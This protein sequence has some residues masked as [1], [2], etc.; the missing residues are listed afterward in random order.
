[1]PLGAGGCRRALTRAYSGTHTHTRQTQSF[2][3][4]CFCGSHTSPPPVFL[5]P[6]AP[7]LIPGIHNVGRSLAPPPSLGAALLLAH[8]DNLSHTRSS[9]THTHTHTH[10]HSLRRPL[11]QTGCAHGFAHGYA[12][13]SPT[14][15]AL[16]LPSPPAF[17]SPPASPAVPSPT[18]PTQRGP[19]GQRLVPGVRVRGAGPKGMLPWY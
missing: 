4:S 5:S 15:T 16:L 10:T 19:R 17:S 1:M 13:G 3:A 7:P 14:A 6:L 12:H 11:P 8:R 18:Q 2:A 9:H